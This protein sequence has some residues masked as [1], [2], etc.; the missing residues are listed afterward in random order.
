MDC[1]GITLELPVKNTGLYIMQ[2]SMVLGGRGGGGGGCWE[3]P[4]NLVV[5]GYFYLCLNISTYLI[6]RY[7]VI[8][9]NLFLPKN[10]KT[11]YSPNKKKQGQTVHKQR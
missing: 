10:V 2:S 1:S 11:C 6:L 7:I 3:K 5:G 4:K 9:A 8:F